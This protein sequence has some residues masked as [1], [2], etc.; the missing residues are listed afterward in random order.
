MYYDDD[1]NV[2]NYPKLQSICP[3]CQRH[4]IKCFALHLFSDLLVVICVRSVF[5]T[6][7]FLILSP[8]PTL[9]PSTSS[10]KS[11]ISWIH[12]SLHRWPQHLPDVTHCTINLFMRLSPRRGQRLDLNLHFNLHY[13]ENPI[14]INENMNLNQ[15]SICSLCLRALREKGTTLNNVTMVAQQETL[16]FAFLESL[17]V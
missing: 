9:L 14:L 13:S 5:I 15:Q 4:C 6:D 12:W 7:S 1:D 8:S 3:K 10:T 16:P 17:F 2:S 11:N